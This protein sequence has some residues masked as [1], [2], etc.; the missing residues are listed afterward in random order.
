[1]NANY[2][3]YVFFVL[4]VLL[5]IS[6][7]SFSALL[8]WRSDQIHYVPKYNP[9]I[10]H[11]YLNITSNGP[12]AYDEVG[13]FRLTLRIA[14]TTAKLFGESACISPVATTNE[15]KSILK[16]TILTSNSSAFKNINLG[17]LYLPNIIKFNEFTGTGAQELYL[18]MAFI[19]VQLNTSITVSFSPAGCFATRTYGYWHD[20]TR[21]VGG[22]VPTTSDSV[23]FPPNSGQ[24]IID[25][26]ITIVNL[27]MEGGELLLRNSTCPMSWTVDDRF[28]HRFVFESF[29]LFL[30]VFY[31]FSFFQSKMLQ[32]IRSP[33]YLRR[34]G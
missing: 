28:L 20:K 10:N 16:S 3:K 7:I 8:N 31:R 4:L 34:S 17:S 14:G 9:T 33:L 24:I 27:K 11:F 22:S 19:P 21:W 6:H 29:L 23:Y 25:S 2:E 32:K 15:I 30:T 13:N 5:S 12:I 18:D 1:M 26:N